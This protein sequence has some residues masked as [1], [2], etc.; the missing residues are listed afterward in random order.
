MVIGLRL[1]SYIDGVYVGCVIDKH[2]LDSFDKRASW[3]DSPPL[4]LVYSDMCGLLHSPS[5]SRYKYFLTFIDDF[6]ICT[7]VYFLKLESEVFDMFV[8]YKAVVEKQNEHQL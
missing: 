4:R 8:A 5:F 7:W 2:H 6:S 1:L 3:H